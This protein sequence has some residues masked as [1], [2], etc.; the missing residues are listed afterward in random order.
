M[1]RRDMGTRSTIIN[2]CG[3]GLKVPR[4]RQGGEGQAT[5][6]Q[7]KPGTTRVTGTAQSSYGTCAVDL[8]R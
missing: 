4:H 7:R 5:R 6:V 3:V 8:T 1:R 2:G